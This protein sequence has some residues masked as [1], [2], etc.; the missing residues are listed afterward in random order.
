MHYFLWVHVVAHPRDYRQRTETPYKGPL[1][2]DWADILGG[3]AYVHSLEQLQKLPFDDW[4]KDCLELCVD[5]DDNAKRTLKNFAFKIERYH[6]GQPYSY[7][8]LRYLTKDE[9]D[10]ALKLDHPAPPLPEPSIG[11][12]VAFF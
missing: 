11:R 10:E 7:V 5:P 2:Q 8:S 3:R 12:E 4:T 9:L 1:R 6:Q